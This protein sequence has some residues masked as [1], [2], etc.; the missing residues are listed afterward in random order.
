MS[1]RHENG[2]GSTKDPMVKAMEE[3]IPTDDFTRDFAGEN[4]LIME[5]RASLLIF[6]A[7]TSGRFAP[8][9]KT[10]IDK[11]GRYFFK[12]S[13]PMEYT[14]K[15]KKDKSDAPKYSFT[16]FEFRPDHLLGKP[17]LDFDKVFEDFPK[18]SSSDDSYKKAK[19]IHILYLEYSNASSLSV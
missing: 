19:N 12:L 5:E 14:M 4:K 1:E 10:K 16:E 18:P 2:E 9:M 6:S 3:F 17:T 15:D 11:N 8:F 7:L 13:P